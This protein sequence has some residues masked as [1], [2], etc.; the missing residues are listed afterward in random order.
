[1]L[2]ERRKTESGWLLEIQSGVRT[3]AARCTRSE[4][5]PDA[6]IGSRLELTGV[7][8]ALGS[9]RVA[10][11]ETG[12]FE[13]LLPSAAAVRVLARPPWW[14]LER[15]LMIVGALATVLVLAVL[16]ITQLHRQVEQRGAALEKEIRARQQVEQQRMLEQERARVAR[17][18]HDELGSDLTEVG[19]LLS[20]AQSVATTPER[21]AKYLERT[22]AKARQM[23]TALDE[24]V[25]AMNPSHDSLGS[26]TSYFCLHADR[27][28]GLAGVV[29]RLEETQ[30]APEIAVDSRRRH[31]LFLAFKEALT[32][33]VRHAQATEVRFSLAAESGEVRL[34]V[35]DNG[36]GLP[37]IAP[38]DGMD[39]V[40]NL[41]TRCEKLGGRFEIESAPGR[42]TTVRFSVPVN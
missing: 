41:R 34:T 7:Y 13:L 42:G 31:Q 9:N 24:I 1:L 5:P 6:V 39:G 33:V 3:F 11:Q 29:W 16:W 18:L 25:W 26:L 22:D 21:L 28:L 17:D 8:A 38:G 4:P 20:R 15:L 12:A 36:R 32:N 10:G 14:T 27:F 2:V 35:I 23:V 19:M 30:G 40:A 37:G